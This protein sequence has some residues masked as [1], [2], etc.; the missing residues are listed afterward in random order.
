MAKDLDRV[1][2]I[3]IKTYN[4]LGEL[5][6]K[7]LIIEIMGK[8][9]NIILIDKESEKIIDVMKK[10]TF[11]MSRVRQLLPGSIYSFISND[12][13]NLL[14]DKRGPIDTFD[15]DKSTKVIKEFYIKYDGL[16]PMFGKVLLK[17]AGIDEDIK[18]NLLSEEDKICLNK[19]YFEFRNKIIENSFSPT[20]YYSNEKATSYYP[21]FVEKLASSYKTFKNASEMIS[22]YYM[23]NENNDQLI[24]KK[25]N[26][27]KIVNSNLKKKITKL[28]NQFD[29][30]KISKD[31]EKYKI[32]ADLISANQ[33]R[34][35][36]GQ[37]SI[38]LENFYSENL[39]KIEIE[40]DEKLPAHA[41]STKYYKIYSKLKSRENILKDE[42]KKSEEEVNYLEQ[43]K[44]QLDSDLDLNEV[45]EI[46]EELISSG[47]KKKRPRK[48]NKSKKNIESKPLEFVSSSN[49]NIFVGKNNKQNDFLT[50]KFA[51][52]EDIFFHVQSFPGSHV[53]LKYNNSYTDEDIVEASYLAAKYSSLKNEKLVTVDYTERKNVFKRR[54]AKPGMVNY[55]NFKSIVVDLYDKS[56]EKKLDERKL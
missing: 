33:Y 10:V 27:L 12:K 20:I 3:D 41:N 40:L 5:S 17:S 19:I 35:T 9:S 51:N 36:P 30:Y 45:L 42:I 6:I 34:I 25:N 24:E 13:I 29:E 22:N 1:I 18:L 55:T 2:G 48:S 56:I 23:L 43:L 46:E 7:T 15:F 8:H 26:L 11:D 32:W 50:I 4:E 54:G 39:E 47:Y 16:G 44:S 38:V 53:I 31:R 28:Q 49:N 52:K 21:F 14:N 37:K